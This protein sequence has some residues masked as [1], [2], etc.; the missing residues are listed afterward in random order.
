MTDLWVE[1]LDKKWNLQYE[2]LVDYKTKNGHCK[3]PY[4]YDQDKALGMW[5]NV[6]RSYHTRKILRFDRKELLDKI[7]FAWKS[8]LYKRCNHQLETNWNQQY[9]KLVAFKAKNGHCRVPHRYKQDKV[10]GK[11]IK[12]QQ[13]GG[14]QTKKQMRPDRKE[15]LD[16]IGLVWTVHKGQSLRPSTTQDQL[17]Y[18]QYEKL[19]EFKRKNGHCNLERLYEQDEALGDWVNTQHV[20]FHTNNTMRLDRKKLLDEIG[21]VW[22]SDSSQDLDNKRGNQQLDKLVDCKTKNGHSTVPCRYEQDKPPGMWDTLQRSSHTNKEMT[23]DRN[24]LLDDTGVVWTLDRDQRKNGGSLDSEEYK[25]D[26]DNK[27][28]A[29]GVD[30]QRTRYADN[31]IRLAR[32]DLPNDVEVVWKPDKK[33]QSAQSFTTCDPKWNIHFRI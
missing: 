20:S 31:K 29:N 2:K 16:K 14:F 3:V 30:A 33:G 4:Y 21:F 18:L 10:L 8:N 13:T 6:Q 11:W 28:L 32:V 5:V 1:K 26:K 24:E 17:W 9:E 19:V 27:A 12:M 22:K 7:G 23:L 25:E 15:L